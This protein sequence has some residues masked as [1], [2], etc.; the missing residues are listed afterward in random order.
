MNHFERFKLVETDNTF[1]NTNFTNFNDALS[2]QQTFLPC[3]L[4]SEVWSCVWMGDSNE[5]RFFHQRDPELWDSH[6]LPSFIPLYPLNCQEN[7]IFL[8]ICKFFI[9]NI[10]GNN[11]RKL[12]VTQTSTVQ[13]ISVQV[14]CTPSCLLCGFVFLW[15]AKWVC[16]NFIKSKN[17]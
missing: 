4:H 8:F 2:S 13:H 12:T 7:C 10:T 15:R 17:S 9:L 16:L 14:F 5:S 3:V 1:Q 11:V 6:D